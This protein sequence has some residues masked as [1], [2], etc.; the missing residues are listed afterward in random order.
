VLQQQH[1]WCLR[2][3]FHDTCIISKATDYTASN[4]W[5][6]FIYENEEQDWT[7]YCSLWDSTDDYSCNTK[8]AFNCNLQG[9]I[10][11]K[12]FNLTD[13]LWMDPILGQ[14]LDE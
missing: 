5:R 11:E 12:I 8:L 14:F 10:L 9:A 3:G 7:E 4:T 2:Y 1:I 13:D 6:D